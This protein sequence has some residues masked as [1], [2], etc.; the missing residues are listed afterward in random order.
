MLKNLLIFVP[1]SSEI[2][3]AFWI[4]GPS[5]R[6]SENGNPNSIMSTPPLTNPLTVASVDFSFGYPAMI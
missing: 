1:F 3:L 2:V 4:T 6:G 5:A